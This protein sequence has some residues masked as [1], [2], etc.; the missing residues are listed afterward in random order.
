MGNAFQL[1]PAAW[2]K[3]APKPHDVS[4]A[5]AHRYCLDAFD[6]AQKLEVHAAIL[7]RSGHSVNSAG[8]GREIVAGVPS[9]RHR[10]ET[11]THYCA[12]SGLEDCFATFT[13]GCA[14]GYIMA[15]RWG[16]SLLGKPR[17]GRGKGRF[18]AAVA[19]AQGI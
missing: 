5:A 9:G 14:L 19:K 7:T 3:L 10:T 1:P 18:K 11:S 17:L 8:C 6:F 16:S 2:A 4:N 12:P 13:Q 15:P